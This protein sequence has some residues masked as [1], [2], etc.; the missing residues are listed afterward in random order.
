MLLARSAQQNTTAFHVVRYV[1]IIGT[2]GS[3][4][5]TFARQLRTGA[6]LPL[7]DPRMTRYWMAM[8]EA[9]GLLW[10]ALA[11]PA[12]SRTLLDTGPPIPVQAI[13][14]RVCQLM[15]PDGPPPRFVMTGTRPGE[16]LAEE[17]ASASETLAACGD[18]P[19]WRVLDARRTEHA[20]LVGSMVDELRSLLSSASS[21]ELHARA[22]E[23]A[24]Q[25]Q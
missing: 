11:L 21:G 6:P 9:L 20:Q 2:S 14:E 25:L 18:D 22:M 15:Q 12:A 5:E 4:I 7:T 1:N 8:E 3:V 23:F 24:R 19:V 10:H 17:L 16:R 13:A